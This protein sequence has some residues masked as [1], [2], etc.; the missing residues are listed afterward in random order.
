M[1]TERA[2]S[3]VL[4]YGIYPR[5]VVS[6]HLIRRYVEVLRTGVVFKDAVVADRGSRRVIDGFHRCTAALR[7]FGPEAELEVEWRDYADEHAMFLDA[8][9][10]NVAH[11]MPLSRFDAAHC[12]EVAR[13]LGVPEDRMARVLGLTEHKYEHEKATRFAEGPDGQLVLLKRSVQHMAGHKL[14]DRQVMGNAHASGWPL[15]FHVDQTINMLDN[16]LAD[17]SEAGL[18]DRLHT[19]AHVLARYV[20]ADDDQRAG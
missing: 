4:D 13:R 12:I 2:A 15:R 10:L 16:G 18:L 6:Q 3:L 14:T 5:M 19:L 7:H 8:A 9:G 20:I 1:P 11:G 17:L